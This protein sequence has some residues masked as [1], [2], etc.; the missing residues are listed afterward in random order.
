MSVVKSPQT[1]SHPTLGGYLRDEDVPTHT[2]T[3]VSL[4]EG[5]RYDRLSTGV[6]K[7]PPT[8][9]YFAHLFVL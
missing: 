3:G 2:G 7:T 5:R 6:D 8:V 9:T 4:W 1:F